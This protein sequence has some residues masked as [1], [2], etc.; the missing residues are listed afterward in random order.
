MQN[1]AGAIWLEQPSKRAQLFQSLSGA[2]LME[3]VN[4][5]ARAKLDFFSKTDYTADL[6]VAQADYDRLVA[7]VADTEAQLAAMPEPNPFILTENQGRLA[8][9]RHALEQLQSVQA[10][11]TRL[12]ELLQEKAKA[13]AEVQQHAN[14][15]VQ[16]QFSQERLAEVKSN[17][18]SLTEIKREWDKD[19]ARRTMHL[20][21]LDQQK[22]EL[23]RAIAEQLSVVFDPTLDP[24]ALGTEV[25]RLKNEISGIVMQGND[26]RKFL[27]T[28]AEKQCCPTCG[29]T[30][31]CPACGHVTMDIA[32]S[33]ADKTAKR[34]E[35]LARHNE[36]TAKIRALEPA[37]QSAR[38]GRD[39]YLKKG[40]A[41]DRLREKVNYLES[42]VPADP[43]PDK[44]SAELPVLRDLATRMTNWLNSLTQAM[45]KV[46]VTDDSIAGIQRNTQG[47]SAVPL[48]TEELTACQAAVDGYNAALSKRAELKGNLASYITQ[49]GS[50]QDRLAEMV[51]RQKNSEKTNQAVDYLQEL[52]T[53]THPGSIPRHMAAGYLVNVNNYLGAYCRELRL[54]FSLYVEPE[55]LTLMMQSD[56]LHAAAEQHW[57]GGMFS[58]IALAWH[59]T[60]YAIHG[61]S[62]NFMVFDEPSDGLDSDNMACLSG[63]MESLSAYCQNSGKQLIIVTHEAVLA[64]VFD[65][66]LAVN[67]DGRKASKANKARLKSGDKSAGSGRVHGSGEDGDVLTPDWDEHENQEV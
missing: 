17:I 23:E 20:K 35:L 36:L 21:D 24:D 12:S 56:K 53:A 18:E 41:V 63:M 45:G 60:L 8:S 27:D 64:S 54:P 4:K 39:A 26:L 13:E 3:K 47:A 1:Q 67:N 43:G 25:T 7:L 55:H 44:A 59:L 52:R 28:Y 6:K 29:S 31:I 66:E 16:Y 33:V 50:A 58:M 62:C 38:D 46:K 48:T 42:I 49:R 15:G 37:I 9:H 34:Q 30:G 57:S 11:Q 5:V 2:E 40:L 65:T 14:L 61:S 10:A 32:G 22:A 51:R 19:Q